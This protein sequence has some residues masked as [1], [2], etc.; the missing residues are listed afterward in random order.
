MVTFFELFRFADKTDKILMF[1]G[2]VGAALIGTALPMFALLWGD[3]TTT[4]G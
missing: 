3:M 4:F 1:F 2:T